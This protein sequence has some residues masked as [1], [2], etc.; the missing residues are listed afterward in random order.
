M[1]KPNYDKNEKYESDYIKKA[2]YD[3]LQVIS[4]SLRN[5][6]INAVSKNGGHLASNLGV[7]E[8]TLVL[9]RIFDLPRDK[10]IFDVG[11]QCYAHKLLSGRD[12][13]FESIR[14]YGGLS[15]FTRRD[16][17]EYDPLSAGHSGSALSAAVGHAEAEYLRGGDA[18]TI[19]VIGDGSFT[20]GMVYEAVNSCAER[21]LRLIIILNDNEMSISKNVGALSRRLSR[22]RVSKKYFSFKHFVK[23]A[24]VSIPLIGV[25][26]TNAARAVRDFA[27]RIVI[28]STLLEN[29]GLDYLGPVDGN[30]IKELENVLS[31]AKTKETVC[32]VHMVTKKGKGFEPAEKNPEKWHSASPFELSEDGEGINNYS[33]NKKS[34]STF[35]EVFGEAICELAEND[36]KICAVTAAMTGGTGL[37]KFADRY[38]KR[39]FDVGI[40]EEHEITFAGGL[41]AGGLRPVCA[42]YSTF[43]QRAYDQLLM[44]VA[45]QNVPVTL[46]LDRAGI[47]PGDGVTHQGIYDYS[48]FSTIPDV[49]IYSPE[50]ADEAKKFLGVAVYEEN[51]SIL[52]YPRGRE[53]EYDRS[54]FENRGEYCVYGAD[55]ADVVLV[56]YGRLTSVAYSAAKQLEKSGI[57]IKLVKMIKIFP[58][59]EE[60]LKILTDTEVKVIYI[61]NEGIRSGGFGEKLITRLNQS[62]TL[63]QRVIDHSIDMGFVPHGDIASL[64]EMLGFTADKICK[65]ILSVIDEI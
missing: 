12:T 17:S 50:T 22:I 28:K 6:I 43:A 25:P 56:T 34:Q 63:R 45:L 3:E 19:C 23:K 58:F 18:Y 32:L 46:A 64:D 36:D 37:E 48:L 40:A 51:L 9:H 8:A 2:D 14:R 52:R 38:P 5:D 1:E 31:E 33:A 20:N 24:F 35:S 47:V 26:L 41:A 21:K 59:N 53:Y 44:D 61:L 16:E 54:L 62:G 55:D 39:F 49:T 15:G 60:A 13:Q 29:M 65:D 4:D 42:V 11:H 57:K 10:I 7:V 27:K 30:N